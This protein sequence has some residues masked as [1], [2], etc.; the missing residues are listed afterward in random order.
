MV[1]LGVKLGAAGWKAQTNPLSY[2]GTH[3]LQS[4]TISSARGKVNLSQFLSPPSS[5]KCD[6]K[7]FS[8]T[9]NFIF[10]EL[11]TYQ[12]AQNTRQW[13]SFQSK[14]AIPVLILSL[15]VCL[16]TLSSKRLE[17]DVVEISTQHIDLLDL[18]LAKTCNSQSQCFIQHNPTFANDIRLR[19]GHS[20]E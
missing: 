1:C 6:I 9:S 12:T 11:K 8:I 19:N 15:L 3:T 20:L 4:L 13:R 2:G 17:F 14:Q 10:Q 7:V 16:K 5:I 18:Q